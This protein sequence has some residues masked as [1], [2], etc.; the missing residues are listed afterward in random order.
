[1]AAAREV[2]KNPIPE[3]KPSCGLRIPTDRSNFLQTNY[4]LKNDLV[5][6]NDYLLISYH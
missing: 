5:K 1:M 6:I 4:R 3:I 2:N